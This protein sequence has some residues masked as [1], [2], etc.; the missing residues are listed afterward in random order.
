M[1]VSIII[2]N[3]NTSKLI[4]GCIKSI[5]EKTN[6]IEYEII[7]VDNATEELKT[8]I[9]SADDSRVKLLQLP[10]NIGF[11]RANNEGFKISKGHNILCLNPDTILLNN[12]VKILSDYLDAHPECGACGGNLFDEDLQPSLSFRRRLP[13]IAW[14]FN[15]LTNH[16][17]DKL[18]YGKSR[19]FNYTN[20][21]LQVGLIQGAD[22]MIPRE[23]FKA[24]RGFSPDFFMFFEETDLCARIKSL[25]KSLWSVPEAQIQHLE[26][27]SFTN[28]KLNIKRLELVEEGRINYYKHN[29]SERTLRISNRL[30]K[31]TL[32]L[33]KIIG[34]NQHFDMLYATFC[35]LTNQ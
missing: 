21:P 18:C 32:F 29:C 7:V 10:E 16:T 22:I 35:K 28:K 15:E 19:L 5:F 25:G 8:V 26:G 33:K 24:V 11:G 12:A 2:I 4:N 3:Y 14:E 34:R 9:E 30:R 23:I 17:L 20:K 1:D 31:W 27:E 13:G 6:N